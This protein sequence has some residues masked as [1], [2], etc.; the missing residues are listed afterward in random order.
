MGVLYVVI[1]CLA[2]SNTQGTVPS[3]LVCW[4]AE[5]VIFKWRPGHK[6]CGCL[7]VFCG[8]QRHVSIERYFLILLGEIPADAQY[9]RN[10][11]FV[12]FRRN[13]NLTDPTEIEEKIFEAESRITLGLHYKIPYPRYANY[14]PGF[15]K[16]SKKKREQERKSRPVYMKSYYEDKDGK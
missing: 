7:D 10:E 3:Q 14:S 9:I 4:R 15:M 13:K 12:L 6:C 11:A 5:S 1:S 8:L 16:Q 2:S